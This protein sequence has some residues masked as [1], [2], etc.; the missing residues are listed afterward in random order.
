MEAMGFRSLLLARLLLMVVAALAAHILRGLL[1]RPVLVVAAR[2]ALRGAETAV[3]VGQILAA[4]AALGRT[5]HR[6]QFIPAEL[7]ALGL[8]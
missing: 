8:S 1:E 5:G 4:A 7:A 6:P 3:M 2:L